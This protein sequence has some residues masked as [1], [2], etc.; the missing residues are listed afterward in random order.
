VDALAVDLGALAAELGPSVRLVGNLPYA[1]SSPLLRRL[2]DVRERL[3]GWGV[4]LQRELA[5]RL[6]AEPGTRDYGSLTVLHRLTVHVERVMDLRPG[7]FFPVPRVRSSFLRVAPREDAPVDTLALAR[8]E[9]VVRAAFGARR[10]TLLNA[11]RGGLG[12]AGAE[13]ILAAL[14]ASGIEPGVRAERVEPG[15]FV[16]LADAL[17][18]GVACEQGAP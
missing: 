4:M 16:A 6:V 17:R 7:C 8:V 5:D 3:R 14:A 9:R 15:R 1:I 18:A 12:G 11:L 13:A 2:L 10:K